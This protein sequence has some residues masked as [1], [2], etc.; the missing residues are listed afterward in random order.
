MK[1]TIKFHAGENTVKKPTG[2]EKE[3]GSLARK[4][5][6][7]GSKTHAT[8]ETVKK[9]NEGKGTIGQLAQN[10]A[11]YDNLNA[12]LQESHN[13]VKAIRENPKQYLV[14][15]LKIF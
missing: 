2:N 5:G 6:G 14:I 13:L 4:E 11:V 12:T 7:K 10:R 15:H 1:K 8:T 3:K 9:I